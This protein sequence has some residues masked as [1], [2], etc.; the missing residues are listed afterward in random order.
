[1][2]AEFE[3]EVGLERLV[4]VHANDSKAGLGAGV[5]RHENIGLGQIGEEGFRAV[6]AHPAFREI[7]FIL[8]V[9]GING[10][11]PD[12]ANVEILKRLAAE[13]GAR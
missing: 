8:E 4:V 2:V 1:M 7:P 10:E 9:P 6:L 13:V 11:G 3:R 12:K 5:D